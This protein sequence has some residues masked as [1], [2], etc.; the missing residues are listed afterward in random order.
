[1]LAVT[2]AATTMAGLDTAV[3][4]VAPASIQ[5]DLGA[6]HSTLQWVIVAYGVLLGG[7]SCS[8]DAWPITW[9]V[10]A[11][12]WWS[13]PHPGLARELLAKDRQRD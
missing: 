12:S 8:V 13:L 1:M 11:S 4:N 5:H 10:G 9:A 7:S 6:G 2:C 3:V